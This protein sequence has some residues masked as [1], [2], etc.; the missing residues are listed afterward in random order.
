MQK[1]GRKS[2]ASLELATVSM[3]ETI[4]RPQCPHDLNDE[5]SEVWFTVINRLPA[6]WFPAETHPILSQYCRAVVQ[7]RRVAELIERALS[8]LD[9]D[10]KEPTLTVSAYDRLLKMQVR[11]S[12]SIAM[13]ATKMR[14]SQ[15]ATT[16]HRGNKKQISPKK[17]WE[18]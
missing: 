18:S 16:N 1:R 4:E 17:P 8:D 3:I 5:E 10:T 14:I 11:Q 7:S 13:L 15:Q 6:D 2:A 12:A 9:P